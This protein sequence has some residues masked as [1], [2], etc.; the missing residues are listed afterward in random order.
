MN[1]ATDFFLA[2]AALIVFTVGAFALIG[3]DQYETDRDDHRN[4]QGQK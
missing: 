1:R 4:M 2:A 3:W